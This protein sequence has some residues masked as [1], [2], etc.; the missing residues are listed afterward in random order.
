MTNCRLDLAIRLS[1]CF[2]FSPYV[3]P[4]VCSSNTFHSLVWPSV[5]SVSPTLRPSVPP[6]IPLSFHQFVF[7]SLHFS[8]RLSVRGYISRTFRSSLG[9]SARPHVHQFPRP[10]IRPSNHLSLDT[11]T[12]IVLMSL[13]AKCSSVS[14][15]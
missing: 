10:S 12:K 13:P 8:A 15:A 14:I 4:S 2:S 7:Q 5:R 6:A 3:R 11:P 9:S 1:G